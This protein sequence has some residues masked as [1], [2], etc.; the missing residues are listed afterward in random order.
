MGGASST[1]VELSTL[2]R[3]TGSA[4]IGRDDPFWTTLLTAKVPLQHGGGGSVAELEA[5]Y[6]RFC[7]ELLRNNYNFLTLLLCTL[8]HLEAAQAARTT[9]TQ[10]EQ[11]A[12]ALM[13]VWR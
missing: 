13:L 8:D 3:L 12:A 5:T 6:H 1:P 4:P 9:Q 7:A 2:E 10:L 11:A